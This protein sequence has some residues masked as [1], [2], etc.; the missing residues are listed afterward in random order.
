MANDVDTVR[1]AITGDAQAVL[2]EQIASIE[3]EIIQRRAINLTTRTAIHELL[4]SV[5]HTILQLEPAHDG[6]PDDPRA[7]NERLLLGHEYRALIQRLSEEQRNCWNDIQ[8]L[9]QELRLCERDL[10]A[11][12]QRDKRLRSIN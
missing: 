3:R 7:R 6:I 10:L 5:R 12:Q 11:L 1:A 2:N 4:S 9:K 8:R